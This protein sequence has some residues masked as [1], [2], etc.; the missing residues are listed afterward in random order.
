[1]SAQWDQIEAGSE[2][3]PRTFGPLRRT[4]I[5][6]Y[7]G[8]SG[9]FQPIHHDEPFAKAA[10]Y[11]APLVVGM[12]TAGLMNTWAT[13]WLGPEN[14][15]RSRCRFKEQVWP[16]DV[17]V[18]S[19]KVTQKYEEQGARLVD[20]ELEVWREGG[21]VALQGYMTFLIEA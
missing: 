19:G 18:C 4:V 17:L 6:R 21:G 16:G 11:D 15:R 7:Q 2:P 5:G 14:V 13:D 9:D 3:P 10:G 20:V 8:A 12:L 1:M